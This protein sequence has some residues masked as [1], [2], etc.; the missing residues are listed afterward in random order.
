MAEASLSCYTR[1]DHDGLVLALE[2]TLDMATAPRCIDTLHQFVREHGPD[3]VLDM[4]RLDFIDSKGV[5]ALL[6]GVKASREAGGTV[7]LQ[8]P[9]TPVKKIL[10]MCGLLSLFPPRPERKPEPA[11][12]EPSAPPR[13]RATGVAPPVRPPARAAA[14]TARPLKRAA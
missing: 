12:A 11:A 6:S 2:G 8:N 5:G 4:A 13:P 9:A 14:G 1:R 10:E 7:Y 3:V